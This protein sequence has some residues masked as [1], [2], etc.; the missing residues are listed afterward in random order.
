METLAAGCKITKVPLDDGCQHGRRLVRVAIPWVCEEQ[1]V[2]FVHHDCIH[3]Q[4]LAVANRVCGVVPRPTAEG[5]SALRVAAKVVGRQLPVTTPE[6]YYVMPM[7]YGGAK[8][9]RYLNATDDVLAF[10]LSP[11]DA[12]IKMFVKTERIQP[13]QAKPNPD[14]RAIQFRNARYCVELSRYLKPIEEHLYA[15]SGVSRGV[16]PTRVVAKG[17]NQVER[18]EL[19]KEK[20]AHFVRP[21]VLSLDASRFDKHVDE[22]ALRVEHSVYVGCC[23]D[24]YFALLLSWQLGNR[25]FSS[26][27]LS[28]KVVGKRMSGDMNT[29][30]GNCL[31]MVIMLVAYMTWCK[32]WDLLDDGDDVLLIVEESD[33][34][35][36]VGTVKDAFLAFGHELKVESV[37]RVLEQVEFCQSRPI[38][39][40][41]GKHKFVRNPW[42]VLSTALTGVKYF[43]QDGARAKL[44][45][46]IG[47]CE[48]V[49]SLGV[50]VLQEFALAILRNCGV[51]EGLQLP[52]DGSL[53]S[54]VRREL[55]TLG[56]RTLQRVDPQ[57]VQ[58]CARLSFELAFGMTPARQVQAESSLRLWRFDVTG[59]CE[60][61]PEWDVRTWTFNPLVDMEVHPL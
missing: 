9:T 21:V 2:P 27:G 5:L 41:P 36:V 20:L 56:L 55:R 53:M 50:P 13:D 54:R 8:R 37:T 46:S 4:L 42:K 32:K 40:S 38:E 10:G 43:N 60:L 28:Y 31:L 14:P 18:A 17:L 48:L 44:L 45:Y 15:L 6:D 49:L 57:P 51:D 29:A 19:L 3:N 30:L 1:F 35:R 34:P 39:W 61:P 59:V 16:P 33:L 24:P 23:P 47:I 58:T 12:T 25:C 11:R 26:R 52:P 22:E 7:R